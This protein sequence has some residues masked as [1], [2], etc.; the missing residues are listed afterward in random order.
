MLW[1]AQFYLL[2][3]QRFLAFKLFLIEAKR[4]RAYFVV[5]ETQ[6][7]TILV[8]LTSGNSVD[9]DQGF[10]NK[11][12]ISP[13]RMDDKENF[14]CFY[15]EAVSLEKLLASFCFCF[16]SDPSLRVEFSNTPVCLSYLTRPRLRFR[17]LFRSRGLQHG[18]GLQRLNKALYFLMAVFVVRVHYDMKVHNRAGAST[19]VSKT[20]KILAPTITY[21]P[22]SL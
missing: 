21:L 17:R 13:L 3:S 14:Q 22:H 4:W 12:A 19:K 9:R 6:N 20:K 1:H 11:L 16:L 2:P 7:E 10:G 18:R 5:N 8:K 15:T